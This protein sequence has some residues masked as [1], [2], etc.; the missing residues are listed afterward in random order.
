M[1]SLI[2]STVTLSIKNF[3]ELTAQC[4]KTSI[5]PGSGNYNLIL[6]L[7]KQLPVEFR[8]EFHDLVGD[9]LTAEL[10][11]RVGG[12]L[13]VPF[14]ENMPPLREVDLKDKVAGNAEHIQPPLYV[15]TVLHV[16]PDIA[17]DCLYIRLPV[18]FQYLGRFHPKKSQRD[19]RGHD[20]VLIPVRHLIPKACQTGTAADNTVIKTGGMRVPVILTGPVSRFAHNFP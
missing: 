1:L 19:I 20:L 18:L 8:L 11:L 5:I 10:H 2:K 13:A 15:R 4:Y 6:N 9:G 17:I 7:H 14:L 12:S 16:L 3:V